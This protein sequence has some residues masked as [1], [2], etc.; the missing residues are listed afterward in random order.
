MENNYH[1]IVKKNDE[2][3]LEAHDIS[4]EMVNTILNRYRLGNN[5]EIFT[6]SPEE[7]EQ[8]NLM[9]GEL[10]RFIKEVI[11]DCGENSAL[12]MD[13]ISK[14]NIRDVLDYILKYAERLE[15]QYE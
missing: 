11:E 1:I 5:I 14:K 7:Q 8:Y 4:E 2:I 13:D 15:E 3:L 9:F 6:I 10:I 12:K